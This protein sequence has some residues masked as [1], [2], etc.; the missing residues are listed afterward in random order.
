MPPAMPGRERGEIFRFD[1]ESAREIKA[2]S[3]APAGGRGGRRVARR[4]SRRHRSQIAHPLLHRCVAP[5]AGGRASGLGLSARHR[6]LSPCAGAARQAARRDAAHRPDRARQGGGQRAPGRSEESRRRRDREA[7]QHHRAR[8]RLRLR[9]Q[10]S[11][12][13]HH[14]HPDRR[15]A[16]RRR[17]RQRPDRPREAHPCCAELARR[18]RDQRLLRRPSGLPHHRPH[19]GHDLPVLQRAASRARLRAF[20]RAH[21]EPSRLRDD[22]TSIR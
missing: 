2:Q 8:R 1:D 6:R 9:L 22:R 21:L 18:G 4:R 17:E 16:P 12:G 10:G 7:R 11:R 20:H 5:R 13:A 19:P 14:P 3:R 15:Q